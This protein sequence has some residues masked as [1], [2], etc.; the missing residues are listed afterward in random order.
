LPVIALE[1]LFL[2]NIGAHKNKDAHNEEQ[3]Y[4]GDIERKGFGFLYWGF[5]IALGLFLFASM[6]ITF[7]VSVYVAENK[8]GTPVIA[9]TANL[10]ASI[11]SCVVG[12]SFGAIYRK[13]GKTA[14]LLSYM[15]TAI[16]SFLLMTIPTAPTLYAMAIFRG[17]LVAIASTYCYSII[18]TIVPKEKAKDAIAL[19]AATYSFAIFISTHVVTLSMKLIGNGRYTPTIIVPM[20][21]CIAIFFVQL[22]LNEKQQKISPE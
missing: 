7:F 6:F 22:F 15:G 3:K 19:L 2:P 4:S 1:I 10:I 21:I 9:A 20:T 8:L 12:F 11:G 14:I 16:I 18:P 5:A 13:I 17:G